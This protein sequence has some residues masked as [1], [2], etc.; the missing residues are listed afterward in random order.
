L[1]PESILRL[2]FGLS[3][4]LNSPKRTRPRLVLNQ[5]IWY[6]IRM[7]R[8]IIFSIDEFYHIYNRG[9]EKRIIFLDEY[10]NN[11]FTLLLYL[12]NCPDRVDLSDLLRQGL[13]LHEIFKEE[14]IDTLVDIG[15][16]CLMP[17]HFHLL[18]KEKMENGVAIFMQKLLTSY[19]MYFNFKYHRKGSLFEGPFKA[20]HL[21][22]DQYLKYQFTYIH[23][24]P[25]GIIDSGWKEK[26]IEDKKKA[27]IFLEEYR[28]S[29]YLDYSGQGR[30][31]GNILNREAFPEYFET[32]L[33]FNKM[34]DEWI[35]FSE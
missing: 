2:F 18:I 35:N 19:S 16:W 8:N 24:N 6:Y 30:S 21:D 33:D 13:S 34:V 9:T 29:S 15:A 32:V 12:C 3:N 22:Y 4:R 27:K 7:S 26:Y 25:I 28:Y 1:D 23:L 11:R 14:R 5:H 20:R 17:N 10:D 31:E